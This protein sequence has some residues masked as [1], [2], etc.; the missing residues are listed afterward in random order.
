[1]LPG[2]IGPWIF[3]LIAA[4]KEE[5]AARET[6]DRASTNTPADIPAED[7]AEK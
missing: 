7:G 2:D 5:A 6:A 1:M 3:D 4:Q